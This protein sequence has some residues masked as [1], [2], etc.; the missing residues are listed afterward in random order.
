[1]GEEEIEAAVRLLRSKSPFRY[2]GIALR[3]EVES[4]EKE[5]AQF[6]GVKHALAVSSG[7]SAIATALAALG[8]GPGQEVIVPATCGGGG[9][10]GRESGG[11]TGAGGH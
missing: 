4:F 3:R 6:L 1:M 8:V 11:H 7:S 9:R 2:Y 5:F 10:G